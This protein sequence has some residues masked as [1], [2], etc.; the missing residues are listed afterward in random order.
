MSEFKVGSLVRCITPG[1]NKYLTKNKIYVI[2][3]L[4]ETDYIYI[5]NDYNREEGYLSFRFELIDSKA[6]EVLYGE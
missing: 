5:N 3:K 1:L 6:A 4:D 2:S